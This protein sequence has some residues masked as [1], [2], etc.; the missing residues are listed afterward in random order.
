MARMQSDVGE[1]EVAVLKRHWMGGVKRV[2]FEIEIWSKG[3]GSKHLRSD[4]EVRP[5]IPTWLL[6]ALLTLLLATVV[7]LLL[8]FLIPP[9]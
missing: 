6:V 2:P 3:A 5:K 9:A 4:L 1:I 8:W 7:F